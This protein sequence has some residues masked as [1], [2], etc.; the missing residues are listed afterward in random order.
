MN[1][2][3]FFRKLVMERAANVPLGTVE[4]L[5]SL[6]V[7]V[8]RRRTPPALLTVHFDQLPSHVRPNIAT[9]A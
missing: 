5:Q 1:R 6:H 7:G 3:V 4:I 2:P 9:Y 8:S